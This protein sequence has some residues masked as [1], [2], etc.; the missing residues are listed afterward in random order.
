M[1]CEMKKNEV[2]KSAYKSNV[3][4]VPCVVVYKGG[5]VTEACDL[6]PIV[7]CCEG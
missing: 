2:N 1:G 4:V 6:I 3:G 5:A 7:P